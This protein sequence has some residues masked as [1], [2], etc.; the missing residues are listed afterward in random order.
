MMR[1]LITI[2]LSSLVVVTMSAFAHHPAA[3]IVDADIYAMIDEMVANTPHADLT[4]DSM[5]GSATD[6][7]V[8]ARSVVSMENL[9]ED[10]LLSYVAMLDGD[11]SVSIDF[12]P[13]SSVN[14]R[15]SQTE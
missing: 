9:L 14:F 1:K 5:G 2:A 13:D 12:N 8:S 7:T 11:V 6:I 10:G 4:F 3:D 15:V